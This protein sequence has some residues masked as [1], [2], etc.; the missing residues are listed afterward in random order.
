MGVQQAQRWRVLKRNL[1][2]LIEKMPVNTSII[3]L[4]VASGTNTFLMGEI[5][6][7]RNN[8]NYYGFDT[9]CGYTQEDVDEERDPNVKVGLLEN[10]SSGRWNVNHLEILAQLERKSLQDQCTL[11]VGDIKKTVPQFIEDHPNLN[12]GMVYIDCN[13]YLPA[14]TALRS[15]ENNLVNGSLIVVDEHRVGGEHRAFFEFMGEDV[16]TVEVCDYYLDGP[17]TYATYTFGT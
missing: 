6:R 8:C 2:V 7:N 17:K 9:F 14:I 15:I 10:E 11:V 4:G 12:I 3:E 16:E 1:Y 13:A 5:I